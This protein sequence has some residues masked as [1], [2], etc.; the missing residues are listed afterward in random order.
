MK[1]HI[2]AEEHDT[3]KI[4]F[5]CE[6]SDPDCRQKVPLTLEDYEQLHNKDSRFVIFPGHV[7][8]AVERVIHNKPTMQVVDKFAL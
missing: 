3:V 1:Q 8:P 7:T 4:E 2:P 6:C 5:Y